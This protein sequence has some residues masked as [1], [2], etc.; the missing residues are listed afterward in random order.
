M[1]WAEY[2]TYFKRKTAWQEEITSE[3]RKE[4]LRFC[5]TQKRSEETKISLATRRFPPQN[6]I[7]KSIGMT[8]LIVLARYS[9]GM[10]G[11]LLNLPDG[12]MS[13]SLH[14]SPVQEHMNIS[15]PSS[16]FSLI[17]HCSELESS[18]MWPYS[19][20]WGSWHI[21]SNVTFSSFCL[22]QMKGRKVK[23]K[24]QYFTQGADR[25]VPAWN[26]PL[27]RTQMGFKEYHMFF[28]G[29]PEWGKFG[30]VWAPHTG[31]FVQWYAYSCIIL[32][33][34]SNK[35]LWKSHP[36]LFR[37][38]LNELLWTSEHT[39]G[40]CGHCADSKNLWEIMFK[41]ELFPQNLRNF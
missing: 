7:P 37:L 13:I 2:Q 17:K 16:F 25:T 18:N 35:C 22:L 23:S 15:P 28:F 5:N 30:C 10:Q 3:H 6:E 31:A 38:M 40:F 1:S 34:S 12:N 41:T 19:V 29:F 4:R 27:L 36:E 33:L 21:V 32:P 11:K 20:F 26:L 9:L 14:S 8:Q 39:F 24:K